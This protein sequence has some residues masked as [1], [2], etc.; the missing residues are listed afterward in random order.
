MLLGVEED[1]ALQ[2]CQHKMFDEAKSRKDMLKKC[3]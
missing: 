2:V 1:I 3:L